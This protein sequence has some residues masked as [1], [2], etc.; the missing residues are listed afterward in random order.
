MLFRYFFQPGMLRCPIHFQICLN[1]NHRPRQNRARPFSQFCRTLGLLFL[2]CD[3]SMA[4]PHPVQQS[5]EQEH[6]DKRIVHLSAEQIKKSGIQLE[7][8]ASG[9]LAMM[10]NLP[11]QVAINTDKLAQIVPRVAGVIR[12]VRKTLGDHVKAGDILAVI[13]SRE[14]ADTRA[15]YLAAK[16]RSALALATFQRKEDLLHD[17]VVSQQAYQEAKEMLAVAKIE[18]QTAQQKLLAMGITAQEITGL[19]RH[20]LESLHPK[21]NLSRYEIAAPFSGTILERHI[22]LG[23]AVESNVAIFRLGDLNTVWVDLNVYPKDLSQVHVGQNVTVSV[24]EN[25]LKGQGKIIHVQPLIDQETRRTFARVVLDNKDGR[26][27]PGLFVN[28]LVQTGEVDV[29]I[30]IA[31][32]ALQTVKGETV[33]FVPVKDGFESRSVT[34]GR[35]D[36]NHVE[37]IGGLK[38]G[39]RYVVTGGLILKSEQQK[40][41]AGEKGE[42]GGDD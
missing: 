40:S 34:V 24:S 26:W 2:V 6:E 33:V 21:D 30:R 39:E 11:G 32:S 4:A 19:T 25:N 14:L 27:Q 41:E 22:T 13:D 1:L 10:L 29:P 5:V 9:P 16:E 37:I 36:E 35:S 7:T 42:A 31:R 18:E 20:S 17:K 15:A 12:E 3:V 23:E 38:S 8:A 28:G